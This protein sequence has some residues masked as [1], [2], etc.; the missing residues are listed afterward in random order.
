LFSATV[1]RKEVEEAGKSAGEDEGVKK[2]TGKTTGKTPDMILLLLSENP[3]ASIP[4][5]AEKIEKSERAVERAIRKLREEGRIRRIG[6]A[7]GGRWEVIQ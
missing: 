3:A 7:K 4:E 5:L 1:R 6:P 2:T